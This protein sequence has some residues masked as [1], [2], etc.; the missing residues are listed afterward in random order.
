MQAG[1]R[2]GI[3]LEKLNRIEKAVWEVND[4]FNSERND[5]LQT[6]NQGALWV[7]PSHRLPPGTEPKALSVQPSGA[8]CNQST[9]LRQLIFKQ[10]IAIVLP[11]A[12][13]KI[14]NGRATAFYLSAQL[15][16]K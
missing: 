1:T 12:A 4:E 13:N 6:I 15:N 14:Q 5:S 10:T 11:P 2:E 9:A 16:N 3:T 8:R 7:G